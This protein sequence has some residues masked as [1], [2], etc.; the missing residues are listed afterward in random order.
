MSFD[1]VLRQ[2]VSRAAGPIGRV[3]PP[4]RRTPNT[5]GS[6]TPMPPPTPAD[7][8]TVAAAHG[9]PLPF[10]PAPSTYA[11]PPAIP[12]MR[13]APGT[14]GATVEGASDASATAAEVDSDGDGLSDADEIEISGTD[15]LT[16]DSDGD[17]VGDGDEVAAGTDPLAAGGSAGTDGGVAVGATVVTTDVVNLRTGASPQA[18]IVM[19]LAAGTLLTVT[20]EPEQA[21]GLAWVPVATPD[22][23]LAGYV[24]ADFL[25]Q[26]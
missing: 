20:G 14:A 6:S 5:L 13:P 11:T 10:P 2:I 18:E 1:D 19:E 25:A 16:F 21:E 24:A 4:L 8:S 15:P 3:A 23:A 9:L 17:G 26:A 12:D 7:L 22:G